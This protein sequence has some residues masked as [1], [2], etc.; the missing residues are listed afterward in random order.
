MAENKLRQKWS[1]SYLWEHFLV[2]DHRIPI[3]LIFE[4]SIC[5]QEDTQIIEIPVV[6]LTFWNWT[7]SEHTKIIEIP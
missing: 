7:S 5:I 6:L 1:I 2:P 3:L 4:L